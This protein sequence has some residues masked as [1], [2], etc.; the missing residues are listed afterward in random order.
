[1]LDIPSIIFFSMTPSRAKIPFS[2]SLLVNSVN[3]L[4]NAD[5]LQNNIQ[6]PFLLIVLLNGNYPVSVKFI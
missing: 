1:M 5:N 4:I 2:D 3:N 6:C